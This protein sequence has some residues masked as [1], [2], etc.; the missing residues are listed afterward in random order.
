VKAERSQFLGLRPRIS[1]HACREVLAALLHDEARDVLGADQPQGVAGHAQAD[2]DLRAHRHPLD[3]GPQG[4]GQ[5]A[6][7]L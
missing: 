7:R 2:L 6:S 1:A 4:L 5:K 3:E